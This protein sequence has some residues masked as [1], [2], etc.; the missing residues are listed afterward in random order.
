MPQGV[1]PNDIYH[2]GYWYSR[3]GTGGPATFATNSITGEVNLALPSGLSVPIASSLGGV[4]QVALMGDSMTASAGG[5]TAITAATRLSG[6]VTVT[7][8]GHSANTGD[9]C[10]LYNFLDTSY[11]NNGVSITRISATQVSYPSAG[12]D[13]STTNLNTNCTMQLQQ[14]AVQNSNSYI[15][16]LNAKTGGAFRPIINGGN[17]GNTSA[18]MLTRFSS[19][20]LAYNPQTVIIFCGYNDFPGNSMT[21]AQVYAN[22]T[23]MISQCAGKLVIVVSAIPWTT[24]GTTSN[25]VEAAKYNR[26]IRAYCNNNPRCRFADAAKYLVDFTNGTRFSPLSGMLRSDGIHPTPKGAERIAQAILDVTQYDFS[27][28]SRLVNNQVDTYGFDATNPNI[29]DNAPF[30]N[31]GGAVTGGATGVAASQYAVTLGGTGT[32]V[33]S[34]PARA[35]GI[36]YDQQAVFTPGAAGASCTFSIGTGYITGRF[37][38]GDKIQIL[39]ELTMSGFSGA[40]ISGFEVAVGFQGISGGAPF[41]AKDQAE[42]L[43]AQIA[44]DGTYTLVSSECVLPSGCT[45]IAFTVVFTS[46]AAGTAFTAK[47]GRVSIEKI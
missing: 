23:G 46:S 38:V 26:L 33:G 40:N 8:S 47:L 16:W 25:R 32:V 24:G 20:C 17:T 22:V 7:S 41:I 12:I 4:V 44:I 37:S 30:V 15:F 5:N 14:V 10:R 19:D 13:G 42:N 34:C 11:N 9:M 27:R 31:T 21:A 36:G 43:A 45:G 6:V 3:N 2:N 18:Q 29:L 39:G 1:D 35:D 28:P